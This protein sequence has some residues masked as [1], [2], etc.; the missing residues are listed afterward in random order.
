VQLMEQLVYEFTLRLPG[1][2]LICKSLISSILTQLLRNQFSH[3]HAHNTQHG[4]RIVQL[5]DEIATTPQLPWTNAFIASKLNLS[6]DH[7]ARLFK[8]IAG[9]PPSEFIQGIRHREA[10][11]LLRETDLLI[12]QIGESVGYPD[13]HHFSRIFRKHEGISATEYRKLSKVL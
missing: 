13:I 7:T 5:I 2:E 8:Q 12:E 6:I 10:R 9:L 1:Y 11:R 3:A 4:E